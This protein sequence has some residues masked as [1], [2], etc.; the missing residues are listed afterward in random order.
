M[1]TLRFISTPLTVH[2]PYIGIHLF[3]LRFQSEAK[4]QLVLQVTEDASAAATSAT[5]LTPI[6]PSVV[7]LDD[8]VELMERVKLE[9]D[10]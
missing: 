5:S 8:D 7:A 9:D 2:S 10:R 1:S 4:A 6:L 3:P